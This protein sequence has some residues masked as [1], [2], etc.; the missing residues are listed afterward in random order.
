MGK[1]EFLRS[2]KLHVRLGESVLLAFCLL[3]VLAGPV[4]AAESAPSPEPAPPSATAQGGV[5]SPT[6]ESPTPESAP[7]AG[8]PSPAPAEP[9]SQP[10]ARVSEPPSAPAES[11]PRRLPV[12]GTRSNPGARSRRAHAASH[13]TPSRRA[14]ARKQA[15]ARRGPA[16]LA[17]PTVS[18]VAGH[19]DGTL[20]LLASGALGVVAL[21]GL[22]L[23]RL[24][25]RLERLS[26]EGF[27]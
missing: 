17:S 13:P 6:P 16:L 20:L 3:T 2:S 26:H 24:L 1:A 27:A 10:A 9:S 25:I 12:G 7:Q 15:H 22:T 5:E 14:R 8:R 19:R 23:V 4:R 11:Q 21:A 18:P